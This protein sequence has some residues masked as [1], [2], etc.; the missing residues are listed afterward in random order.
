MD[1][2]GRLWRP[3]DS[4]ASAR[5]ASPRV[6][7]P[8][9]KQ[10]IPAVRHKGRP[11]GARRHRDHANLSA[12]RASP[13]C[14]DGASA[15]PAI[16]GSMPRRPGS[17]ESTPRRF[18]GAASEAHRVPVPRPQCPGSAG[19]PRCCLAPPP[20]CHRGVPC[21]PRHGGNAWLSRRRW[22]RLRWAALGRSCDSDKIGGATATPPISKCYMM[23]LVNLSLN[24]VSQP[25]LLR[26]RKTRNT[27][28]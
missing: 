22:L 13:A 21:S 14:V 10:P 23:Q 15:R 6:A 17:T 2:S 8:L 20:T 25:A 28:R 18:Q 1:K 24:T 7:P 19:A 16:R 12:S 5:E 9:P 27:P 4:G 26:H 3:A 11:T